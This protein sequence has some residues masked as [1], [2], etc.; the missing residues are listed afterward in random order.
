MK[1]IANMLAPHRGSTWDNYHEVIP[2]EL[3]EALGGAL[4]GSESLYNTPPILL[5]EMFL[6]SSPEIDFLKIL[7]FHLGDERIHHGS[8]TKK[9][10]LHLWSFEGPKK[11]VRYHLMEREIT[12]HEAEGSYYRYRTYKTFYLLI[13]LKEKNRVHR[14][15]GSTQSSQ[16]TPYTAFID[17][18]NTKIERYSRS[19]RWHDIIENI[20]VK[21]K[22]PQNTP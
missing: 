6:I 13:H 4:K 1:H 7:N 5:S 2:K 20:S 15:Y 18:L 8:Q 9:T 22:E 14:A 10:K 19:G 16:S 21:N 12:I 17:M 11:E 3:E